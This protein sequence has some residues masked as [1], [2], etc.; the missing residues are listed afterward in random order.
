MILFMNYMVRGE[1]DDTALHNNGYA[2]G[3]GNTN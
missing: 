2:G 3:I 1:R